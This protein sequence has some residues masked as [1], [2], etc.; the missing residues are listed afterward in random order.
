MIVG[1]PEN[2]QILSLAQPVAPYS[3]MT[4][5]FEYGPVSLSGPSLSEYGP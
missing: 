3:S 2:S 1:Y 4:Q 5:T